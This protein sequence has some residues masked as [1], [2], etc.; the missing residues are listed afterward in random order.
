LLCVGREIGSPVAAIEEIGL[1][2]SVST[3]IGAAVDVLTEKASLGRV[4]FFASC[5]LLVAGVVALHEGYTAHF[6]LSRLERAADV[7][8]SLASLE[9]ELAASQSE[10]LKTVRDTL[11]AELNGIL[12]PQFL[13]FNFDRGFY[14]MCLT[15]CV[16][17]IVGWTA[18]KTDRSEHR[19][20]GL[21]GI[22]LMSSPFIIIAG[23]IPSFK[24]F[25]ADIL[26]YP[27]G[28][29]I[30]LGYGLALFLGTKGARSE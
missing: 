11:I 25:W 20:L 8:T 5:L 30:V 27:I 19:W 16:W 29:V 17:F 13:V 24:N 21:V 10:E 14:R 1:R 3:F 2:V 23:L 6:R 18:L 7:A 4:L 22:V 12:R 9:K 26:I 28:H 15:A